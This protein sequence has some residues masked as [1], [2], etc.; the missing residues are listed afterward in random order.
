MWARAIT[1]MIGLVVCA[2]APAS[3]QQPVAAHK[4]SIRDDSLAAAPLNVTP[5][6]V[7][8]MIIVFAPAS[9]GR[10]LT[11]GRTAA[12]LITQ[13]ADARATPAQHVAIATHGK[14]LPLAADTAHWWRT[15]RSTPPQGVPK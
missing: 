11:T 4:A 14:I 12:D 13:A 15:Q 7:P 1:F 6:R 8:T 10:R 3:A 2:T 5:T 9:P